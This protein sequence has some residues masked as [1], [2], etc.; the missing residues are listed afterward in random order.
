MKNSP[1]RRRPLAEM[2]FAAAISVAFLT[3]CSSKPP[4]CAD[5]ETID[6]ARAIILD[7]WKVVFEATYRHM[8]N[9]TDEQ[10]AAFNGGLKLEIRD[11]VSDGYNAD[12]KKYSCNGVFA[13]QTIV[14][15]T[16]SASRRFTSQ[17]IVEGG[18]KFVVEV[19][20]GESLV[21]EVSVA[22]TPYKAALLNQPK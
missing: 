11:I 21:N 10:V 17:A 14:G 1:S 2:I 8:F 12:A 6:T 4:G 16:Y 20:D 3:A 7:R 9:L 5:K 18:G 19:E 15:K 22:V 13:Y